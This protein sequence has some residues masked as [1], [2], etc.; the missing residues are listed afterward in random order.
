MLALDYTPASPRPVLRLVAVPD[1]AP[2]PGEL[3]LAVHATALNRADLL[4]VRGQYP[5]PAGE[6][7]VPGLEAAGVVERVGEGVEG[8][9]PGDRVMALLAGGGHAAKAIVPVG[10]ALAIPGNLSFAEGAAIPEVGLTAWTNLVHEG[11]LEPGETVL[12]TA[13][14]SGVGSF[15]VQ[16]ARELGARVLVAGRS[17]ER[18]GRLLEL[19]AT[20]ALP[21][22]DEL[23][24]RARELTGGR[25][26]DLVVDLVGGDALA[27]HLECLAERGRLVLVGL[28]GGG[29]AGLDLSRLMRRRLRVIGSV[30]RPRSRGEKAILVAAFRDYALPRLGD[31]RLRAVVDRV[32]PFAQIADAYAALEGGGVLGKIVLT[33]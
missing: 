16:L 9:S 32:V 18:L 21:L 12:V 15:V 24:S 3:L 33:I 30:L 23:P 5:P 7:E 10:Q 2:G 29:R 13:A 19:G 6:S 4:Q 14:A 25:G 20:A 1:P 27:T 22:G 11:R 31:G 28:L 26:V 8:W 17:P